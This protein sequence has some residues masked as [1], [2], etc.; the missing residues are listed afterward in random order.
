MMQKI[1]NMCTTTGTQWHEGYKMSWSGNLLCLKTIDQKAKGGVTHC[2]PSDVFVCG[3]AFAVGKFNH[4]HLAGR[5][6]T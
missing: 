3:A 4:T 2:G 5:P 1:L 6:N